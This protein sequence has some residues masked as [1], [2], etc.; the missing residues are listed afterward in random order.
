MRIGVAFRRVVLAFFA[1]PLLTLISCSSGSAPAVTPVT[2]TSPLDQ[3]VVGWG[4]SPENAITTADNPGGTEQTYRLILLPTID[5]TQERLHFSNLY[6]TSPITIGSVRIAVA[7]TGAAIDPTTDKPVTFNGS[8]S[9]TIPAGQTV[10]SD[11]VNVTYTFGQKLSVSIYMKGTFPSLTRHD[12]Q[13]SVNYTTGAGMGDKTTDT[14][15]AAFQTSIQQWVLLTGIDVYGAYQ[16]TVVLYGSSSIDGHGSNYSSTNAYPVANTPVV[17]QDN[18]RPSDWLA[19]TLVAAGYRVGVLNS[20]ELGDPA[21]EDPNSMANNSQAGVDRVGRDVVNQ[22][23]VKA[24]VIYLGGVDLRSDC[25]AA[26]QVETSLTSIVSQAAAANVRVILGTIPPAEYCTHSDAS[27]LPNA[28][29]PWQGD[30]NPGPENPGST[31]RRALNDWIRTTGAALPGVVGIADFDAAL[32]YP[33]H[34]DFM[35]PMFTSSDNFHPTGLGYQLQNSA[36]PVKA[37]LGQ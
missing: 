14:T 7:G 37:I 27:L 36:I 29:N 24:V 32:A 3:W 20:G 8:T 1:A 31:Q 28:A 22:A 23:G 33:A 16:G 9:V 25:V 35:M 11:T 30:V 2:S 12:S 34:P 6:G 18:D 17:G 19:R 10:T 5:G 13:V 4:A 15:G 26:T 21:G